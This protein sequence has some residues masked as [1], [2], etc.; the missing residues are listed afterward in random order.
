LALTTSTRGFAAVRLHAAVPPILASALGLGITAFD[1]W[2]VGDDVAPTLLLLV[3]CGAL[4]GLLQPARAWRWALWLG[5]WLPLVHV[6]LFVA[7]RDPGI[8][9]DTL[10]ARLAIIPVSVTAALVGVYAGVAVRWALHAR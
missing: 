2:V 4:L 9:P 8:R 3:V 10:V 5:L 1:A 7:G 6:A